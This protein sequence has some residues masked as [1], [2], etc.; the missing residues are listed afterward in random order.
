MDYD[1]SVLFT[2]AGP[3]YLFR[4]TFTIADVNAL[5][6]V[7]GEVKYDDGV[8][9]YVNGTQIL[10]SSNLDPA[11]T[12]VTYANYQGV[13]T[14]ADNATQSLNVPLNLLHNGVNTIAVEV[15][16]HDNGSSDVTFD[17]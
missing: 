17:L 14:A 6:S 11:G 2:Q 12:L 13:A 7:T 3:S 10:R 4:N 8:V 9:V 5:A 16:Q 15:H 1:S